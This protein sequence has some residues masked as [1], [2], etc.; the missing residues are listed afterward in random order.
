MLGSSELDE[1]LAQLDDISSD[2]TSLDHFQLQKQKSE[3]KKL[4]SLL[5]SMKDS[6]KDI[7]NLYKNERQITIN[8]QQKLDNAKQEFNELQRQFDE[9]DRT[10]VNKVFSLNELIN[11]LK[12]K[13]AEEHQNYVEL[14]QNYF[15]LLSDV[16]CFY[17]Y[18]VNKSQNR[19]ISKTE[20]FLFNSLGEKFKKPKIIRSK[21][22][23]KEDDE[24][25]IVS[26]TSSRASKR[27]VKTNEPAKSKRRKT[28]IWDM[29]SISQA[30]SPAATIPFEDEETSDL[31][32]EIYG[33]ESSFSFNT[34]SIGNETSFSFLQNRKS[35][36]C[37]CHLEREVTLV[38]VGTNTEDPEGIAPSVPSLLSEEEI[39]EGR[40]INDL[41]R[42]QLNSMREIFSVP[43]VLE[44]AA[45]VSA[46]GSDSESK[47][48][49]EVRSSSCQEIG[50]F[51]NYKPCETS[52]TLPQLSALDPIESFDLP[53]PKFTT[54]STN[55]DVDFVVTKH[56]VDQGTSPEPSA[57][58]NKS[59]S[60]VHSTTTR[61]TSTVSP[62]T[63]SFGVQTPE[64]SL[65]K[66]FDETIFELPDCISPISELLEY[67]EEENEK[68]TASTGTIT[69]LCN[70]NREIDYT[71]AKFKFMESSLTSEEDSFII[72]GQTLFDLFLKR[73]KRSNKLLSDDEITRKKI[74]KLLKRQLLDRFSELSF[75]ENFNTSLSD[76]E[77]LEKSPRW[78]S[79]DFEESVV[80]MKDECV[81]SQCSLME[82]EEKQ[83]F[84][85]I[86]E[87]NYGNSRRNDE[88]NEDFDME[89]PVEDFQAFEA[90]GKAKKS[91][92]LP[93]SIGKIVE[94]IEEFEVPEENT[95]ILEE[96][97]EVPEGIKKTPEESM[98]IPEETTEVP[99]KAKAV[100]KE[101]PEVSEVIKEVS[102]ETTEVPE[103]SMKIPEETTE[104]PKQITEVPEEPTKI[105]EKLPES[106]FKVPD[107]PE[108]IIDYDE[109]ED[110]LNIMKTMCSSPPRL[111]DPL[112]NLDDVIWGSLF[113]DDGTSSSTA[114]PD[115][116]PAELD[117]LE[118]FDL[119]HDP[120]EIPTEQEVVYTEIDTRKSPP[121]FVI[122]S[123]DFSP[124]EIPT[125]SRTISKNFCQVSNSILEYNPKTRLNLVQWQQRKTITNKITEKRLCKVRKA[126]KNYLD[127]EWTDENL[128]KCLALID[129]KNEKVLV[130]AIAETVEDNK[131]EK[132]I[133]TEFTPP[134]PPLPRYQ[135]KLVLLV[136]RLAD[137]NPKLP[138][139]LMDDLE[140]KLFRL[141]NSSMEADTLRNTSYYY[142]ALVDL[143]FEGDTTLTFYFIV[144]CLY[145]F[146]AKAIPMI[147]V[148]IK[149]FPNSLPKKNLLLKKYSP[150][151]DWENMTGLEISK[152]QF[153]FEK[154]DSLD[155]TVMYLLTCI[156]IYRTN[157]VKNHELFNYLPKFYGFNLSFLAAPRLLNILMKRL[158]SG[159]L[160]N[161]SMSFI[162]LARRTN[163]DFMIRTLLKGNLLPCL[164]KLMAN[165]ENFTVVEKSQVC[166]LVEVISAII[167]PLAEEKEKSFKEIFPLIVGILGRV[168][169]QKI[170]ETCIRAILRLQRFI[171]NHKEIFT[172]I[173]HHQDTGGR[174]SDGLRYSIQTFI[175]RKNETQFKNST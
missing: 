107:P 174:F 89:N 5:I 49:D 163:H 24:K 138:H 128:E 133:N 45:E 16:T 175:H 158:Q 101:I 55:T 122:P 51:M 130:D 76:S 34:F 139:L 162:L 125:D 47:T 168:Q 54:T 169:C 95:E 151:I 3:N 38:S 102:E 1:F 21:R 111:L 56:T 48:G 170:Q 46:S 156:Q 61:G 165:H 57:K 25:S 91:E 112:E 4:K 62:A 78:K 141:E 85:E 68:I 33:P 115:D 63:K 126:I 13:Q 109:F 60:T 80:E 129:P 72:L 166:L 152:A 81:S 164:E 39:T 100:P 83:E 8:L 127:D 84:S 120:I 31:S 132:E 119:E 99:D 121:P 136:K 93:G 50:N 153:D 71:T 28:D 171:D 22:G 73:I 70:V 77:N 124:V 37:Q 74:W 12:E 143:F 145:I 117:V 106:L 159:E 97:A 10:N 14:G 105:P 94:R 35:P 148:V 75:D 9:I 2:T 87:E 67:S 19:I 135:Q 92:K 150:S 140:E 116:S 96:T 52:Q 90:Q 43:E 41:K 23:D 173:K 53:M 44:D 64:I 65:E 131:W 142:T 146:G 98:E 147:F 69:E 66:I 6:T 36:K 11:E 20:K 103:K 108:A 79:G 114:D 27:S 29:K 32:S 149:A 88:R 154:M 110:I 144:K 172:I 59:T 15:E 155:L 17:N 104:F 160:E 118:G 18:E 86:L 42:L 167:K 123:D 113:P 161:L 58:C 26:R 137:L 7:L 82:D 40:K 30:S 134:A 157:D